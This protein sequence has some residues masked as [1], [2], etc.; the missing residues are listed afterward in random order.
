MIA[1]SYGTM[2]ALIG[3]LWLLVRGYFAIR[4]KTVSWKRE[5]QLVLVYICLVVVARFTFC[6]FGKVDGQIQPLLF[7][8]AQMF[9][10]RVFQLLKIILGHLLNKHKVTLNPPLT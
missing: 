3:I 1:V 5:A 6:P 4:T 7:D 8:P 10:P 9:P 2:V